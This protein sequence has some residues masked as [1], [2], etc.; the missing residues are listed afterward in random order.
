MRERAWLGVDPGWHGACALITESNYIDI[1][2]WPEDVVDVD[3]QLK[4]WHNDY[5]L[6]VILEKVWGRSAK[7]SSNYG[8]WWGLLVGNGIKYDLVAAKTWQKVM[9]KDAIGKDTK[10]KALQKARALF[11][12]QAKQLKRQK[13]HDRADALLLARY[14]QLEGY[15]GV[16]R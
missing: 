15:L 2:D 10:E 3:I 4:E 8:L 16:W 7:L 1:M 9:L 12:G 11:P 6:F 14:G 13:D 5:D